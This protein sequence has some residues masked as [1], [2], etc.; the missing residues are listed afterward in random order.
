[1]KPITTSAI[2]F[3]L[4]AFLLSSCKEPCELQCWKDYE[5]LDEDKC[6]CMINVEKMCSNGVKDDPYEDDVD[7]GGLCESKL[8][9]ECLC[10]EA[11][12][13]EYCEFLTNQSSKKWV[14]AECRP[15]PVTGLECHDIVKDYDR[16]EY[17]LYGGHDT[18]WDTLLF[19]DYLDPSYLEG[20]WISILYPKHFTFSVDNSLKVYRLPYPETIVDYTWEFDYPAN[21]I[22]SGLNIDYIGN[23]FCNWDW[24]QNEGQV[25][26]DDICYNGGIIEKLDNDTLELRCKAEILLWTSATL[27]YNI[28]GWGFVKF[29]KPDPDDT[30][31]IYYFTYKAQ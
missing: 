3:L 8:G 23:D 21:P 1:M 30:T 5:Y 2:V 18:A 27:P 14:L 10:T 29:T 28:P 22:G 13:G 31:N 11:K 25:Y 6:L 17:Y 12:G 7:C 4:L 19:G 16:N 15:H 20:P 24:V 9:Y 26:S